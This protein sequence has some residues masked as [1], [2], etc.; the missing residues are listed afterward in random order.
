MGWKEVIDMV[1]EEHRRFDKYMSKREIAAIFSHELRQ[2]PFDNYVKKSKTYGVLPSNL[3]IV[4][5]STMAH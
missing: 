5:T 1:R 2:N 3:T 4:H